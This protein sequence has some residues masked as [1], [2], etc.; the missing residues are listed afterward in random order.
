VSIHIIYN[1]QTDSQCLV[2]IDRSII[3]NYI[4]DSH[5]LLYFSV[6][7]LYIST[8]SPAELPKE[9]D[10]KEKNNMR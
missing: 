9:N 1:W 2:G 7:L 8:V 4:L 10:D 3:I 5:L 6:F